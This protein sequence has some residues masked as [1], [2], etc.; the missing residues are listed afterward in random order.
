MRVLLVTNDYPP[1]PGGIQQ[2]L[3]NVVAHTTAD[4]RVLG[5]SDVEASRQVVAGHRR[6]MLPTTRTRRWVESHL[7]DFQPDVVVFG[8]PHPLAQLGPRLADRH[9][10]PYVVMAHGAEVTLPGAVPGLRQLLGRTFARAGLVFAVSEYTARKVAAMSGAR[11]AVLGAGVDLGVYAPA[12]RPDDGVMTILCVSR[13]VPRKGHVRVIEAADRLAARGLHC[14]VVIVG[15][16]RLESRIR[17]AADR[18]SV[19]VRLEVGVPWDR[20]PDLYRSADLFVM[21]AR[22]RWWGLEVEGLGIVYLEASAAGLPVVAGRSGGAPETVV[23]GQTGY[24][25]ESVDEIV[26]AVQ[27]IAEDPKRYGAAARRRAEALYSWEA[28]AARFDMG[29][30]R[31]AGPEA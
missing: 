31:V 12:A 15:K 9:R 25:A 1:R 24:V 21:P 2:Y 6:Y 5:P 10:V 30:E 19:T 17:E 20:L 22:S 26:E 18:A 28:V 8:A 16:G 4:V 7:L 14:E 11:T 29:L 13:F 23:P 27:L 3:G